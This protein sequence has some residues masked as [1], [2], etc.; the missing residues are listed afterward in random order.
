LCYNDNENHFHY[1]ELHALMEQDW[2]QCLQEHG[3]HLTAPRRAIVDVLLHSPQALS[4]MDLFDRVRQEYP[5]VGL[6]T[7][8]RTLEKLEEI[9]LL[10]RVHQ[11]GGCHMFMRAA[12]GHEHLLLC[13]SCGKAQYFSGDDIEPLILKVVEQTSFRV[14]DHW[15]QF[16]GTCPECQNKPTGSE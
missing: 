1:Q 3:Y 13:T 15:L 10:Q 16:F 12:C 11:P 9:G 4:P 14:N 8:Y 2:M 7:V 5:R 6:V